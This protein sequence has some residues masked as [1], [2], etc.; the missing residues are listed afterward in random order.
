MTQWHPTK[1]SPTLQR[2]LEDIRADISLSEN[3]LA[4][5]KGTRR[6]HVQRSGLSKGWTLSKTERKRLR[7]KMKRLA[8]LHAHEK[9]AP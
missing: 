2:E 4:E 3:T 9:T 6:R 1:L 8:A 5:I 7:D